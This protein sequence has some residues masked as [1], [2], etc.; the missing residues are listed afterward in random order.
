M[1]K[2]GVEGGGGDSLHIL[3]GE[4]TLLGGVVLGG[5]EHGVAITSVGDEAWLRG[6]ILCL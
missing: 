2:A 1:R 4:W 5:D 3:V 6:E